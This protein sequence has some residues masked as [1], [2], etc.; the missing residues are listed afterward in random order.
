MNELQALIALAS[1]PYLGS[2]KI[3]LLIKTFGSALNALSASSSELADLP[4]FGPKIIN[5]WDNWKKSNAWKEDLALAKNEGAN[6]IPF[7]DPRYPKRL[8]ETKDF[9]VLLYVTGE[10]KKQDQRSI[11]IVGTRQPSSY[12]MQM[13]EKIAYDL[14]GLGFT[15]VSG[16]AKGIDT[17]AHQGALKKGRTIAVIGSGLSDIYPSENR[18]LASNIRKQGAMISEFPMKTPPDRQNFPQ[19]NRIVSGMTMATLLIEAPEK[20]GAMLTLEKGHTQGRKLFALPG[21]ANDENFRGNHLMIKNGKAQLVENAQEI[22]ENF[23]NLFTGY[24][25]CTFFEEQTLEDEET[26]F[27]RL[28]PAQELSIHEVASLTCLPANKLDMLLMSLT[29][30]QI[31]KEFPGKI[32]KKVYNEKYISGSRR[33]NYNG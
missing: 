17:Y 9:P 27:L 4:G 1:S 28:L 26:N 8:L 22:A 20:S 14:T 23:E 7:T 12:G 5:H 13:A 19:R 18:E 31:I 2:I 33:E 21:R 10:L 29:S 25:Q 3:R 15:I 16:L 6:I 24:R 11:A 32:Y 30:K